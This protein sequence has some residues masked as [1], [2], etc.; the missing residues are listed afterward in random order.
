MTKQ[1]LKQLD[2]ELETPEQRIDLLHIILSDA[3]ALEANFE[4]YK[5]K[6][7][8]EYMGNYVLF[9]VKDK[10]KDKLHLETKNNTFKRKKEE[11]LDKKMDDPLFD[12]TQFQEVELNLYTKPKD[13]ITAQDREDIP[14]LDDLMSAIEFFQAYLEVQNSLTLPEMVQP[15]SSYL[16]YRLKHFIIDLQREQYVLRDAF[17]PKIDPYIGHHYVPQHH[18]LDYWYDTMPNKWR[19]DLTNPDQVYLLLKHYSIL[20]ETSYEE[21]NGDMKHILFDLE[22]IVE[23]TE[24]SPDRKHILIRKIDKATNDKIGLELKELF[25]KSYDGNYISRIWKHEICVKIADEAMEL[26]M[27]YDFRNVPGKWRK[28]SKCG[29]KLFK[30][31]KYFSTNKRITGGLELYCKKCEKKL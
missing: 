11:S 31:D 29:E 2:Y 22:D 27:E 26:K 13:P 10:K 28:C 3:S 14:E 9:A 6:K 7:I 25:G 4:N 30:T 12:K 20:R 19:I 5:V 1:F 8:L 15:L 21:L 16:K 23:K 17:K 18:E 24:L